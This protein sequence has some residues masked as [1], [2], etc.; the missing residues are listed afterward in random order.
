MMV[1]KRLS[2]HVWRRHPV[3]QSTNCLSYVN[4]YL[5]KH[6]KLWN[7]WDGKGKINLTISLAWAF[8][9][10][11]FPSL[12]VSCWEKGVLPQDLK[13]AVIVSL[14]KNMGEKSDCS[15]YRG[16]ALLS[17]AGKV[18]ARILLNKLVPSIIEDFTPESQCGFRANRGT[19]DVIF[20]PSGKSRRNTE[21]KT[22]DCMWPS[23]T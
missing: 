8:D 1:G 7:L 10:A 20:V 6:L 23:S 4:T 11:I 21:N 15:N 19:T 12:L 3:H 17:M 22:W 16:I 13:D 18:L 14:Y 2:W 5:A 9:K